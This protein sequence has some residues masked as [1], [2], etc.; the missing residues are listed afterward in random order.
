MW[1]RFKKCSPW[2]LV[3]V[4]LCSTVFPVYG[5]AGDS[6]QDMPHNWATPALEWAVAHGLLK[7]SASGRNQLIRPDAPLS[8]GELA[9]ILSRVFGP[10]EKADIQGYT[11]VPEKAWYR[12][13]IQKTVAMDG[14]VGSNGTMRPDAL[15]TR[16]EVFAA[17][18]KVFKLQ[19]KQQTAFPQQ[20]TDGDQV[21]D[22]ALPGTVALWEKGIIVGFNGRIRPKDTVTRAEFVF[23]LYK[24]S[25][26]I[27]TNPGTVQQVAEG[28]VL[29][30]CAD[31]VLQNV[32]ISGDLMIAD[33]VGS[34][35]V[36]LDGVSVQGNLVIRGGNVHIQNSSVLGQVIASNHYREPISV[37]VSQ[38]A[39][40]NRLIA[41]RGSILL[42]GNVSTITVGAFAKLI[43]M[44][45]QAQSII[46]EGISSAIEIGSLAQ[47]KNISIQHDH[48]QLTVLGQVE[49][50]TVGL[51][52][53]N[54][55]ITGEGQ[56]QYVEVFGNNAT[57]LTANTQVWVHPDVKGTYVSIYAVE[58]T[59]FIKAV[60]QPK[61][62]TAVAPQPTIPRKPNSSKPSGGNIS[63]GGGSPGGDDANGGN[64]GVTGDDEED[65]GPGDDNP[66]DDD[67]QGRN[68]TPGDKDDDKDDDN[69]NDSDDDNDD[70]DGDNDDNQGEPA[71]YKVYVLGD[72]HIQVD[73]AAN[74]QLT[75]AFG[76]TP[77]TSTTIA[78]RNV[79]YDGD[80]YILTIPAITPGL[81]YN[82]TISQP[83]SPDVHYPVQWV[84]PIG[85]PAEA[86]GFAAQ[87]VTMPFPDNEK[88][89]ITL[90]FAKPAHT[91]G[92]EG[93]LLAFSIKEKEEVY[94]ALKATPTFSAAKYEDANQGVSVSPSASSGQLA[95][96]QKD[97]ITG[98]PMGS[99]HKYHFYVISYG[100]RGLLGIAEVSRPLANI[101]RVGTGE[102]A[103]AAD[104]YLDFNAYMD[105]DQVDKVGV[106]L[107]PVEPGTGEATLKPRLE[108]MQSL[109]A[110]VALAGRRGMFLETAGDAKVF[111]P[112]DMQA[113]VPSG[114]S[115]WNVVQM[116][117]Q[118]T[119]YAYVFM[120]SND[121]SIAYVKCESLK[122]PALWPEPLPSIGEGPGKGH[123]V[124]TGGE[125]PFQEDAEGFTD[126]MWVNPNPGQTKPRIL[127]FETVLGGEA[128][129]HGQFFGDD[130]L[131]LK[132][133][134]WESV[135]MP[136]GFD[137]FRGVANDPYFARLVESC[138]AAFFADGEGFMLARALLQ[139]DGTS[140]AVHE[141]LARLWERGGTLVGTGAGASVLAG[142]AYQNNGS[143]SYPSVYANGAEWIA[144]QDYNG[145]NG[146]IFGLN[147]MGFRGLCF[148][149]KATHSPVLL[150][151]RLE[152]M[153]RFG[154]MLVAL[155]D[156]N[157]GGLAVG[158][159]EGTGMKIDSAGV[160]T[161]FGSR[162]IFVADGQEAYW[163]AGG[164]SQPFSVQGLKLHVLTQGDTFDFRTK[165]AVPSADKIPIDTPG[166]TVTETNDIF[167]E[168]TS[169]QYG[170]TRAL[171][172]LA[173][174]GQQSFKARVANRLEA[175]YD[176]GPLFQVAFTKKPSAL[177][178]T[179]ANSYPPTGLL[180]EGF[181]HGTLIDMQLDM[182]VLTIDVTG[183]MLDKF[184][185][186]KV[187]GESAKLE[188]IVTPND[189]TNQ[190]VLWESSDTTVATV[191]ANGLVNCV[192]AG[193]ATIT[194]K[195]MSN[196]NIMDSCTVNVLAKAVPIDTI[197]LS[198][199]GN[200]SLLRGNTQQLSATFTPSEA[201]NSDLTWFS[202]NE[203]VVTVTQTGVVHAVGE[204]TAA[205]QA[206]WNNP[207]AIGDPVV[208]G[209]VSITVIEAPAF[210]VNSITRVNNFSVSATFSN[211]IKPSEA[212]DRYLTETGTS[213]EQN[214][215]VRIQRNGVVLNQ[216][217]ASLIITNGNK[218][219]V[220]LASSAGNFQ[221]G[222]T[223]TFLPAITDMYGQPIEEQ[224]WQVRVSGTTQT[225]TRISPGSTLSMH[226]PLEDVA[227][228]DGTSP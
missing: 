158:L 43:F 72:S 115:A 183:I 123:L 192:G 90:S 116:N 66:G 144:L 160:A 194:A 97:I 35:M 216:G 37:R 173:L 6:F 79:A 50:V 172:Q 93:Y 17:L 167:G 46:T 83:G 70:N 219:S 213:A 157:P 92:I 84:P 138:N 55:L 13:D 177:C 16:Q 190:Q 23:M 162:S 142:V 199:S 110:L 198:Q 77:A 65:N 151:T 61:Q 191:S 117:D 112:K 178:Y 205:V 152:S 174:S 114:A 150:D 103:S 104:Y 193:T 14:L 26:H 211:Q 153:G 33:S 204:G 147:N 25:P 51:G 36:T 168:D 99:G 155:R 145:K 86:H 47:V 140:T 161:V 212:D 179:S 222:D 15:V 106:L 132:Q 197:N 39:S 82:L 87:D 107:V 134:G 182:D 118:A 91:S 105:K 202:N 209:Q 156:L 220:V 180:T 21:S 146:S 111:L 80:M 100:K 58:V 221:T 133:L 139:D 165:H 44:E 181:K 215:Y 63:G 76:P 186:Q 56:V 217:M 40:V 102:G 171:L 120:V 89:P 94:H 10:L 223:I 52:G 45:G 27:I 159:D 1:A 208:T 195:S 96:G 163:S 218:L 127:C 207:Y 184:I 226:I 7:G 49:N 22:W 214:Q 176:T 164:S 200:L 38:D 166:G 59:A 34:G 128:Q 88:S 48:A 11:D 57:V 74:V 29:V 42:Y 73:A 125:T 85:I 3:L 203:N 41:D 149:E 2:L 9:A 5:Q 19:A 113:V 131:A 126:S 69:N 81:M 228:E 188:V 53:R 62:T 206:Q 141:A 68:D 67:G 224:T 122:V 108:S 54:A 170:L 12:E 24:L 95:S 196:P 75:F 30:Q 124:I 31:V 154:R 109:M 60:E 135:Y 189:A 130:A 18:G 169:N 143:G 187:A 185:I 32:T 71:P 101:S 129:A 20:F 136:L 28:T 225:W 137:N 78:P 121:E 4:F 210:T 227:T 175:P 98:K 201:T 64:G 148:A 119:Y 8:R